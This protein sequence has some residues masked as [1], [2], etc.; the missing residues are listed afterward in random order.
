MRQDIS[1]GHEHFTVE[2][3]ATILYMK[4][5]AQEA[6]SLYLRDNAGND[7]III[8][9]GCFTSW[10]Y[11]EN[12]KDIDVFVLKNDH[13]I[14]NTIINNASIIDKDLS[15][16]RFKETDSNYLHNAGNDN[17]ERVVLDTK[18]NIQY[19][20]TSYNTRQDLV[21][22]FDTEHS[23]VSYSLAKNVLYI[24]PKTFQCI[25]SLKLVPHNG[26]KIAEWRKE[27][28]LKRGFSLEIEFV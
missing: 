3:K 7:N 20:V 4:K 5:K 21:K 9:G 24:T 26:N 17:I 15:G 19:I 10:F 13:S 11:N 28:F 14:V 12:P 22:H 25:A 1:L 18:T 8:A 27:K 23:C 6:V 16:R 2:Q